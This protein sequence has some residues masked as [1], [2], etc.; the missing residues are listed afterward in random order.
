M[1]PD[2]E[3]SFVCEDVGS[4]VDEQ[5]VIASDLVETFAAKLKRPLKVVKT[6]RGT[7]LV[8][9]NYEPPFDGYYK[10]YGKQV[11]SLKDGQPQATAWRVVAADFVTTASGTGIV[12][13]APAF[14]EV[15]FDVLKSEQ[16]RFEADKGPELINCVASN[17]TFTDEGPEYCRGRWVKD[18]D[19]DIIRDLKKRGLLYHREQYVH[20]YPFC[21][22]AEED[23]LIQYPRLGWF[24]RTTE[25]KDQMLAN[26]AKINWLPEHIQ[27]GRF[28][29]FLESNVDWALSRERYWGTPL[30]IWVCEKTGQMEAVG[31]YDELKEKP[32]FTG[33]QVWLAAKAK[34]PELPDDLRVHKPYIDAVSYDS[35]FA[36]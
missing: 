22:R 28:G 29:K 18:C 19:K 36:P 16:Q 3:Y 24:I 9:R 33:D 25:F 14:G 2:L 20:D 5:L 31:S 26:N 17:G 1:N 34:N 10:L 32:G 30:P 6:C 4:V 13:Q 21:W 27:T 15:D 23:P 8:G 35:P 7:D 12:H 11:A